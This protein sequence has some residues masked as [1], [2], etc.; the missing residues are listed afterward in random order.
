MIA[1]GCLYRGPLEP[2]WKAPP[3]RVVGRLWAMPRLP[4][5]VRPGVIA[6]L[7]NVP[8]H[9]ALSWDGGPTQIVPVEQ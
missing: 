7:P 5:T 3:I 9:M 6:V 4:L 8:T 1:L 2:R